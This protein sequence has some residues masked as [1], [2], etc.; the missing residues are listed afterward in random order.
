M[1]TRVPSLGRV[2]TRL[3]RVVGEVAALELQRV[4]LERTI[5]TLIESNLDAELWIDGDRNGLPPHPFEVHY[6]PDGD[7]GERMLAVCIDIAA[8]ERSPIVIG[9]D[10][11]VLDA[12][13][14]RSAAAAL[15]R[16]D[17]VTGPVADGGYVLIG[18]SQPRADLFLRM[19]WS[20]PTVHAETLAR[21]DAAG[22]RTI[23]LN[24]LW[25]VDDAAGLRRWRELAGTSPGR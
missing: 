17:L 8:R 11:P 9:S 5:R 3:A 25:D 18:M 1:F 6:Q 14:L 22:L 21:A 19:V 10:C 7:L 4:L 20:T 2:K 15:A 24:E 13:Y 23:V 16:A 12:A